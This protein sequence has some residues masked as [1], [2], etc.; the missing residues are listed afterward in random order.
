MNRDYRLNFAGVNRAKYREMQKQELAMPGRLFCKTVL[1][2]C[3]I[4]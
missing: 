3:V 2:K 1:R 4:G